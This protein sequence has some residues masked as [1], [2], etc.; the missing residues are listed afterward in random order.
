MDKLW[1]DSWSRRKCTR[2]EKP[3][4]RAN[5]KWRA[6]FAVLAASPG[7]QF[8][9]SNARPSCFAVRRYLV[10]SD[11][12]ERDQELIVAAARAVLASLRKEIEERQ[13]PRAALGAL[14]ML[15]AAL[16]EARRP[17]R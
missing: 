3:H 10:N 5:C 7:A 16:D 8:S 11:R 15:E 13:L 4:S 6:V 17:G 12:A 9:R 1:I 14:R 2:H